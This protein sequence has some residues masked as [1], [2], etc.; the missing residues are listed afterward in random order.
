MH[1]LPQ[2]EG[3][4]GFPSPTPTPNCVS[5]FLPIREASPA[6]TEQAAVSTPLLHTSH[7]FCALLGEDFPQAAA[8]LPHPCSWSSVT[9]GAPLGKRVFSVQHRRDAGAQKQQGI[10]QAYTRPG[11]NLGPPGPELATS[12]SSY[13][14][15]HFL[16]LATIPPCSI[17]A[18]Q[19]KM[20]P[21]QF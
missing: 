9:F 7:C 11:L 3:G 4:S 16:F 8:Q 15:A 5:P 20:T 18:V 19:V 10:A 2:A 21:P 12:P 13:N 6:Q 1:L 14:S 17:F